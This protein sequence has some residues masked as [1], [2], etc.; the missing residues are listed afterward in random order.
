MAFYNSVISEPCAGIAPK[1]PPHDRSSVYVV[2]VMP[3]VSLVPKADRP[4]KVGM[5]AALL[6]I[7]ILLPRLVLGSHGKSGRESDERTTYTFD[8]S[9]EFITTFRMHTTLPVAAQNTKLALAPDHRQFPINTSWSSISL[10]LSAVENAVSSCHILWLGNVS[11]IPRCAERLDS[12]VTI[13]W[14]HFIG[15][16]C[17]EPPFYSLAKKSR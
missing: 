8:I 13:H 6:E 2:S 3:L 12:E 4:R 9:H 5:M 15:L 1:C 10:E 17:D 16:Y 11:R 14:N 7:F